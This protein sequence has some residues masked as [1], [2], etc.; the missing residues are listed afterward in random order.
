MRFDDLL[1]LALANLRRNRT[2]S[3]LTGIGVMIGV[4]ALLS[5]LS[6]GTGVQ[7]NIRKEYDAM[8]LYNT[9]RVTSRPMPFQ[10]LGS[11]AGMNP[12]KPNDSLPALPLTDSL[13]AVINQIEGV[14]VAYPEIVFPIEV[15]GETEA[16]ASAEAV[17]MS[18][19]GIPAYQP[20]QGRYFASEDEEAVIVG[21]GLARR[22]GY[23]PPE[24]IVDSTIVIATNYL[25]LHVLRANPLSI[26]RG[27]TG[28]PI[29]TKRYPAKVVGLL[30]EETQPL[31]GFVRVLLPQGWASQMQKLTFF[32]TFDLLMQRGT[33]EG[34]LALRVQLTDRD[35]YT[36]VTQAITDQGVYVTG[37]R[38]QFQQVERIFLVMDLALGIV[39]FI[40]LLVSV[41]GIANTMMMS[42]MERTR[43]IGVMKALGGDERDLQKLFVV[44]SA[45]LGVVGGVVGLLFGWG[46]VGLLNFLVNAYLHRLGAPA[47]D[48]F[49]TTAPMVLGILLLAALVSLLAGVFPARRAARVEPIAA[50]RSV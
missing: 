35:A 28:L 11:L 19:A 32:S 38:E 20:T 24:A 46:I 2:R 14:L 13:I 36:A 43:E 5:L 17:P 16:I 45:V 25:N 31:A 10:S 26:M 8:A 48:V 39:G 29:G 41:I 44:E 49:A 50:L 18:F 9:L 3:L 34:Y 30:S 7:Q 33:N 15:E 23:D 40:A 12:Q 42:V 27:T 22:L 47:L 1:R 37:F 21:P 4:A 6:Y